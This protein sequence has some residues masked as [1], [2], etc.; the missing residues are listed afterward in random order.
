MR[1]QKTTI[2]FR[3]Y[4]IIW[5]AYFLLFVGFESVNVIAPKLYKARQY[6]SLLCLIWIFYNLFQ[7]RKFK[8]NRYLLEGIL[9]LAVP[10]FTTVI[11][12][13]DFEYVR[14]AVKQFYFCTLM[15]LGCECMF[16][17]IGIKRSIEVLLSVFEILLYANFIAMLV[18]PNGVLRYALVQ[19]K[20]MWLPM[21]RNASRPGGLGRVAWLL[22]QQGLL[23]IYVVPGTCLSLLWSSISQKKYLNLRTLLFIGVC[24]LQVF[25]YSRSGNCILTYTIFFLVLI[26]V[27]LWW[28]FGLPLPNIKWLFLILLIM[29]FGAVYFNLPERFEWL[30]VDV[31]HRDLTL[32]GR[33]AVW[34]NAINAILEKPVLGWGYI[35]HSYATSLFVGASHPHNQFLY[36]AYQ[37]GLL[38]LALFIAFL[39]DSFR[40]LW[41]CRKTKDMRM[42][43]VW[44]AN[45]CILVGMFG[46]RYIPYYGI[47]FVVFLLASR[48][49]EILKAS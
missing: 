30:I 10:V 22:D 40:V 47:T 28:K 39:F 25:Y 8:W 15:L 29:F 16:E 12:N 37:G 18:Y 3:P 46:D 45:M 4:N 43:V 9:F 31:L 27:P 41:R 23:T 19:G 24:C 21:A 20:E 34:M 2:R 32:S 35:D 38:A 17:Q 26:A 49:P 48:I 1:V 13:N 7:N 14:Y 11:F 33:L 44:A 6:S 5:V 42:L 36:I